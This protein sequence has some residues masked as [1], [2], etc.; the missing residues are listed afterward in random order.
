LTAFASRVVH[1]GV[2]TATTNERELLVTEPARLDAFLLRS[3][4]ALSRRVARR[5]IA[6]GLVRVNGHIVPKGTRVLE[7]DRIALPALR[8]EPE[9][10]LPVRVVHLDERLIAVEKPGGM[11]SH[12]LDPRQRGTVAGFLAGR[13]PET[14]E[15]GDPLS[16]GLAHRLDTGTSGLLLAARTAESYDAL[17]EAFRS[18]AVGKRYLALVAGVPEPRVTI[19]RPLAHDPEDRRRMVP[20]RRGLR[21]WPARSEVTT[22]RAAGGRALVE[23]T[24]RTGVTHQAR[25]HLALLGCPVLGDALYGGPDAGLAAGR[26]ALHA[27]TLTL[28]GLPRLDSELPEDLSAL[29]PL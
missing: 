6:D 15:L 26:H 2:A 14:A 28:V 1:A 27:S 8:L 13:F 21:A 16:S 18:G 19:D 4:P 12:A 17:R 7:G 29:V 9:P 20:A 3:C 11:P 22:L 24:L 5:L 10:D 23:V 25:V